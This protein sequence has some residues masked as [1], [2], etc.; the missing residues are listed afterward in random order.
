ME[1]SKL[2]AVPRESRGK[3]PARRLR[4]KNL[5]PAVC[6]GPSQPTLHLSIDPKSLTHILSGPLGRNTMIALDIPGSDPQHVLVHDWQVHPIKRTLLHVDFL[7]LDVQKE[8]EIKVPLECTGRSLGVQLGGNL[9]QVYRE[10]PMRC[11]PKD[12]PAKVTVD[13]TSLEIGQSIQAGTLALPAGVTILLDPHQTVLSV[14]APKKEAEV[15]EAAPAAEGA[16]GEATAEGAEG[17]KPAAEG[18]KGEK[19]EKPEKSD[20]KSSRDKKE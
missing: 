5:I 18:D 13:V 19:G 3:G 2:S 17:E 20:R 9:V 6:Y 14:V 4:T 11:L 12:I 15:V 16:E 7:T 10:L 8:V 1:F